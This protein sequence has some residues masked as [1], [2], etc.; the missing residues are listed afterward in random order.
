M[1]RKRLA[2]G[3]Q[4]QPDPAPE[5]LGL[6]DTRKDHKL[7]MGAVERSLMRYAHQPE[8][9][10][11]IIKRARGRRF[12]S[13][14]WRIA[15]ESA[16][17]QAPSLL[18][19][20]K[21]DAPAMLA[22]R[23]T[24]FMGFEARLYLRWGRAL[25]L[26]EMLQVC[27]VECA[28]M[29]S[30]A[31][32]WKESPDRSLVFDVVRHLQARACLVTSEVLTLLRSGYA[33]GA[34][35]R[36]RSIH[37]LAVTAMFIVQHGRDV[38]ERF[39]AHEVVEAYRALGPYQQHSRRLGEKRFSKKEAAAIKAD[40]DAAL[41][42]YGP[43]FSS[44][45]GWAADAIGHP[46]QKYQPKF[47]D[48]EKSIKFEH[49]RPHYKMASYP[50]HATV[51]TIKFSVSLE[52]GTRVM[53]IGPSNAGLADPGHSAAISLGQL[54]T[55]MLLL[56]PSLDSILAASMLGLL[57]DEIGQAFGKA[58]QAVKAAHRRQLA[59]ERAARK[60]LH[61]QKRRRARASSGAAA[62]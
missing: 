15:A 36:W 17:K 51:K 38:A 52:P 22:D 20:L 13:K 62:T 29:L 21:K 59:K 60:K 44:P 8:K 49:W 24:L 2:A 40:H 46:S 39:L 16:K 47:A 32:P 4:L 35:A 11:E 33:S 10:E 54:T 27:C 43:R 6:F 53:L 34:H 28:E 3:P 18:R 31:W 55:R 26:L 50:V 12:W 57:T 7:V 14:T 1:S 5:K 58:D 56:H 37:E 25:D 9:L 42:K 61:G 23:Q 48:L 41:L 30:A 45:Y 19:R